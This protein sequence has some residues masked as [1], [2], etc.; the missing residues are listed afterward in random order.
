MNAIKMTKDQQKQSLNA[1]LVDLGA[2]MT[3]HLYKSP[4]T[5]DDTLT[6]AAMDAVECDF[7]GYTASPLGGAL[8]TPVWFEAL[9]AW[10]AQSWTQFV[11]TG[12]TTPNQV[13]GYYVKN[14][15]GPDLVGVEAFP[16]PV[17]M[18]AFGDACNVLTSI[19]FNGAQL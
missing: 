1:L 8:V 18:A 12:N 13:Y 10:F 7:D 16:V 3:C 19:G 4:V 5:I 17:G 2:T 15:V 6:A 14:S 9:L 11:A